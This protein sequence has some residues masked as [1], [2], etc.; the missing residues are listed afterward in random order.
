MKRK[1][2]QDMADFKEI[3]YVGNEQKKKEKVVS[4]I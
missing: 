4:K 1:R 2:R 3:H